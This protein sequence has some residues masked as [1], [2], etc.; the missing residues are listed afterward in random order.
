MHNGHSTDW[1]TGEF[2]WFLKI[3]TFNGRTIGI[4]SLI[5]TLVLAKAAEKLIFTL[6]E[7]K[8]YAEKVKFYL[9]ASPIFVPFAVNIS[10]D[11]FLVSGIFLII[12]KGIHRKNSLGQLKLQVELIQQIT[13]AA[14]LMTHQL[15]RII[16]L[17]HVLHMFINKSKGIAIVTFLFMVGLFLAT[18]LTVESTPKNAVIT[19]L[20]FDLKCI[21]QH[22]QARIST[23]EWEFLRTLAPENEWKIQTSCTFGDAQLGVMPNLKLKPSVSLFKNYI[24]IVEK[25]PAIAVLGH[26]QRSRGTLP[27]P[28]FQGPDNQ[29][30]LDPKIPIGFNTNIALQSGTELL[31]PSIDEPT[32]DKKVLFLKPLELIAQLPIFL[33]NQ[34]SW[35]WGWGGLWLYPILYFFLRYQPKIRKREALLPIAVLHAALIITTPGPFGRYV[36]ATVL[37]GVTC[38][39]ALIFELKMHFTSIST[40]KL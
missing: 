6:F 7:S 24:S 3:S 22:P 28:F 18:N 11:V 8:P 38:S 14:L 20:L 13:I 32:V 10:H 17:V 2:F 39:I 25:N 31:H 16:L 40:K 23:S 37:L 26:I 34:A 27:P 4:S 5:C 9:F 1:W 36:M 21:A 33:I 35:F 12:S 30:Y 29:V 15:G 19:P